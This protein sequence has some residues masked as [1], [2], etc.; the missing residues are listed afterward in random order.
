MSVQLFRKYLFKFE[1]N[2]L[3]SKETDIFIQNKLIAMHVYWNR[4]QLSIS[5]LSVI[6]LKKVLHT[7]N[8]IYKKMQMSKKFLTIVP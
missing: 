8:L 7:N 4:N 2:S 5:F 6:R 1:A 3:C